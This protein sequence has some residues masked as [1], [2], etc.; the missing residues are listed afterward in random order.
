MISLV[1]WFIVSLIILWLIVMAVLWR[2]QE[3]ADVLKEIDPLVKRG[4]RGGRRIWFLVLRMVDKLRFYTARLVAKLFFRIFPKARAAFKN[5]EE[6]A[7]L[8]Q[9]PSSYFLMSIS[10]GLPG[11]SGKEKLSRQAKKHG[12]KAKNV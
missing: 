5:K 8:E 10:E 11:Q 4:V 9:G 12:R 3:Q 2:K 6:L 1:I 7:G